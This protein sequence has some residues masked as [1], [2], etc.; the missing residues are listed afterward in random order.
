V[1]VH[2]QL[3][4]AR[5]VA[6]QP[7]LLRVALPRRSAAQEDPLVKANFET[8]N[9]SRCKGWNQARVDNGK[10]TYVDTGYQAAHVDTGY[11]VR[12]DTVYQAREDT[13]HNWINNLYMYSPPPQEHGALLRLLVEQPLQLRHVVA[14]HLLAMRRHVGSGGL[15]EL[16]HFRLETIRFPATLSSYAFQLRFPA[17][18]SSY[19]FQL[20]IQLNST[21]CQAFVNDVFS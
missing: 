13:C 15:Y 11:T 2:Q 17:T 7:L 18:L 16:S 12:V 4:R 8:R 20:W 9:H 14:A 6:L 19:A 1:L 10:Q 3:P 21:A 5:L